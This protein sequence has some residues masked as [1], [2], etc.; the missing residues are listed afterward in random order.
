M[1]IEE[2][3]RL[4]KVYIDYDP[5]VITL[6]PTIK[7]AT[8]TGGYTES[9]GPPRIPQ[10]FKKIAVAAFSAAPRITIAGVERIIDYVLLGEY[11]SIMEPGDH[12]FDSNGDRYTVIAIEAGHGYERKGFAERKKY[13]PV[14][15]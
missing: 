1:T 2:Q 8:P 3:R 15:V 13:P 14:V 12:W 10:T 7:T 5:T 6:I 11:D 9:D 4:T